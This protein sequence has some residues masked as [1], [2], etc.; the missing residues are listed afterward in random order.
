MKYLRPTLRARESGLI[1]K[2]TPTCKRRTICIQ[3][4]SARNRCVI[5]NLDSSARLDVVTSLSPEKRTSTVTPAA[6]SSVH[7]TPPLAVPRKTL[8]TAVATTD[9]PNA[10]LQMSFLENA[11]NVR[12][13]IHLA[14]IKID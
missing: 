14:P 12:D 10:L 11:H 9:T 5:A 4:N 6:A 8:V 7:P 2:S 1:K 3:P 13:D